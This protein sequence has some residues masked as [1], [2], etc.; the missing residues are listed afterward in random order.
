MDGQ[1]DDASVSIITTVLFHL[2]LRMLC[3]QL[4]PPLIMFQ[5]NCKMEDKH[6]SCEIS[7]NNHC[8]YTKSKTSCTKNKTT[9]TN[10]I[11]HEVCG[12]QSITAQCHV[13][14]FNSVKIRQALKMIKEEAGHQ[15]YNTTHEWS[16]STAC[17]GNC[18]SRKQVNH[19]CFLDSDTSFV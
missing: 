13:G 12:V 18:M 19:L 6:R 9:K 8:S 4:L 17:T 15:Q 11:L 3:T 1:D 14:H 7:C 2:C 16:L 10:N 5:K